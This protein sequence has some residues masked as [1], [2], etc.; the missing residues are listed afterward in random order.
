MAPL[1]GSNIKPTYADT[2]ADYSFSCNVT[3][4]TCVCGGDLK[5]SPEWRGNFSTSYFCIISFRQDPGLVQRWAAEAEQAVVRGWHTGGQLQGV[6]QVQS[7]RYAR[8]VHANSSVGSLKG[9]HFTQWW[10]WCGT[11]HKLQLNVSLSNRIQSVLRKQ[12][13]LP[14]L[15]P[16]HPSRTDVQVCTWPRPCERHPLHARGEMS[17]WQQALSGSALMPTF[18]AVL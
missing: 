16:R 15:M 7:E 2:I 6:Q 14:T 3:L 13:W 5:F 17:Q 8:K 10:M 9:L 18:W 1:T 4:I 11:E 12:W